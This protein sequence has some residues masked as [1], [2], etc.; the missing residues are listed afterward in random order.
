MTL[1]TYTTVPAGSL[2][3]VPDEKRPEY[4]QALYSLPK[5]LLESMNAPQTGAFIRGLA[6]TYN[7]ELEKA[8]KIAFA[9]LQITLG[10]NALAQLGSILS[11]E[12]QIPNDKAQQIAREVEQELFAPIALELNQYLAQKKQV[13]AA[14]PTGGARNILDLKASPSTPPPPPPIP[15]RFP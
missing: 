11:T 5:A 13:T 14:K 7:I 2:A 10:N 6:K 12:L 8:P 9:I 15:K 1:D 4:I 3:I